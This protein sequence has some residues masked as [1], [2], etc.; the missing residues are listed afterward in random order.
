[1]MVKELDGTE[2]ARIYATSKIRLKRRVVVS[3][4]L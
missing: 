2:M 3:I 4:I 1:M